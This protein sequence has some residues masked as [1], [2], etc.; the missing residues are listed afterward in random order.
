MRIA[1]ALVTGALA[2]CSGGHSTDIKTTLKLADRSDAEL[3][4]LVSAAGGADMFGAQAQV[5]SL[6]FGNGDPCPA[7]SVAGNTVTLTGGCTTSDGVAIDGTASI[8]NPIGWDQVVY[9]YS[10]DTL[11]QFSQLSFTQQGFTT[12]YDGSVRVSDS[13]TVFEADITADQLGVAV[14]SDVYYECDRGSLTCTLDGSGLELVGAGGVHLSGSVAVGGAP[15]AS[16]T[17]QGIDR[18]TVSVTQG[19]VAWQISGS[20]R[21]QVCQ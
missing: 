15:H 20:D 9:N 3:S 12:S 4:R 1:L 7:I 18:M 21:V 2:A 17:L 19:C 14:R 6:S 16:Y 13:S 10:A 5:D 11:Y 8:T